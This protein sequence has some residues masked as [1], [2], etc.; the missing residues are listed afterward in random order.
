LI[1]GKCH[2]AVQVRRAV[3]LRGETAR[4]ITMR[5]VSEPSDQVA[6]QDI[7]RGD[8]ESGNVR[9]YMQV[10]KELAAIDRRPQSLQYGKALVHHQIAI[11]DALREGQILLNHNEGGA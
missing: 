4:V 9:S 11:G 10:R 1:A 3:T 2:D 8:A 7:L 5:E 6:P